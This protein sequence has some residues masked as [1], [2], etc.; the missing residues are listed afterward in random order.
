MNK[1]A[2][3]TA[4]TSAPADPA[5]SPTTLAWSDALSTGFDLIDQHHRSI[6]QWLQELDDARQDRGMLLGAYAVAKLGMYMHEHFAAEEDLMRQAAYPRLQ[7]HIDE[8]ARFRALIGE[9]HHDALVRELS[10]ET[11]Q[12]LREWLIH[13]IG[14]TDMDYIPYLRALKPVSGR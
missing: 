14:V 3:P 4:T 10:A 5:S 11:L 7:E 8:H 6:L 9:L 1:S 2:A 13:H 12:M